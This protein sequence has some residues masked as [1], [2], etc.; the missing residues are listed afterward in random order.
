LRSHLFG[1]GT[2]LFP[3]GLPGGSRR[4]TSGRDFATQQHTGHRVRQLCLP[5]AL[6]TFVIALLILSPLPPTAAAQVKEIRRVLIL[7]EL[8]TAYPAINLIDQ[9]I[10][11]AL[12]NSPYKIEFYREYMETVLFPEPADQ[13]QIR[14]SLLS[15]YR[16][17]RPDVIIT[18]GPIP[19]SFMVETH[20]RFLPGVP[21]IFCVPTS[22]V[23]GSPK[24]DAHFTGVEDFIEAAKT[25]EAALHLQPG[26]EHVVLVG[27]TSAFDKQIEKIVREQLRSYED[28][29]DLSY[30]TNLDMPTLLERLKH[31]PGNTVVLYFGFLQ[32]AAGTRFIGG[33]EASPMIA[34][35]ASAPVFSLFDVDLNH[36]EVGGDVSSFQNDGRIAGSLA[37]RMLKGEKQS[38]TP[39]VTNTSVYMFDW[40]A[41]LLVV[42]CSTGSQLSG[43]KTS[44][45]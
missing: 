30:L 22:S 16:N 5:W 37:L 1:A 32:D 43:N 18:V 38:D 15:K 10:R 39:V 34:A 9:G 36:G 21:I 42:S 24:L 4:L 23:R 33:T 41:F 19:L 35:A 44:G 8:G 17:R 31:L 7:N 3:F 26:T 14:A 6:R 2:Q 25:L 13:Q 12:E 20:E 11:T 29:L 45:T 28:R 27:G 40:R